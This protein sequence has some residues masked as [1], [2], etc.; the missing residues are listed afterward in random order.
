MEKK[1]DTETAK[2]VGSWSN[3]YNYGDFNYC[4]EELYCK[5]TG[6]F[7]LYGFGGAMSKYSQSCGNNCTSGGESIIPLSENG[8]KKW[9]EKYL[10]AD[11]YETIFGEVEE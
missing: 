6:E 10:D 7:F 2:R 3:N 8:A 1:Y 4:S 5:K 9:A 11:E